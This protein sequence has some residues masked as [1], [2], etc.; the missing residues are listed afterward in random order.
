MKKLLGIL[1]VLFSLSLTVN[2][3]GLYVGAHLTGN[4]YDNLERF[5]L[6]YT[7]A[8]TSGI[9]ISAFTGYSRNF[10][11][12][13]FA[14]IGL[15]GNYNFDIIGLPLQTNLDFRGLFGQVPSNKIA[16]GPTVEETAFASSAFLGFRLG[17]LGPNFLNKIALGSTI[18]YYITAF[19]DPFSSD[20]FIN[21]VTLKFSL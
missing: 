8:E 17:F 12:G 19:D 11:K 5:D 21:P 14:H 4:D 16:N 15:A 7:F 3:Q 2:A 1:C 6:G 10:N 18:E 9:E 13:E 20:P